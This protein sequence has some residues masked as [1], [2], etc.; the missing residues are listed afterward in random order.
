MKKLFLL[1]IIIILFLATANAVFAEEQTVDEIQQMISQPR[2]SIQIPGLQFSE[3]Q[4]VEEN[5]SIYL[6]LPFIGE[7]L[8]AVYKWAVVAIGI[9][10]VIRLM[11]AGFGWLISGGSSEKI[12]MER[13]KISQAII[14]LLIAIGS[15]ILLY[16]INPALVEFKSLKIFYVEKISIP[17]IDQIDE[18]MASIP[19]TKEANGVPYYAQFDN[20]WGG[21]A[22]GEEAFCTTIAEAGCGPTSLAMV[23]STYGAE[24]TPDKTAE[25]I[26]KTGNGRKCNKGTAIA[27]TIKKLPESPW[28]NFTGKQI[29]KE[30]ALQILSVGKPIIFLCRQCVGQGN[31]GAKSYK[32]HYMVLTGI[33]GNGNATVN[34]PGANPQKRIRNMT[35]EQ[36]DS[37]GGFWYV[38]PK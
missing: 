23:L 27:I 20:R 1:P 9:L 16:T 8:A 32:G 26:G 12:T 3:P 5:G 17:E 25:F 10:A 33:D 2:T 18:P 30:E 7:Y 15:Y 35:K 28:S 11:L 13:K 37:N 14:G 4:A 22:Y 29:K 31:A 21:N 6:Y 34:D 38:Y 24:V 19:I 36:L